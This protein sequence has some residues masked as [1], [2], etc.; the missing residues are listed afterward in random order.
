MFGEW[1]WADRYDL[2]QAGL[3]PNTTQ[4]TFE[5]FMEED[6]HDKKRI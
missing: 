5:K 1:Y 3:I 6:R 2:F 4:E